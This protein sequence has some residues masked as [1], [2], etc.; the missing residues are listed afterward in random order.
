MTLPVTDAYPIPKDKGKTGPNAK[1][2]WA[3]IKVGESF[4]V[5][6][7]KSAGYLGGSRTCAMKKYGHTYTIRKVE[8]GIRVWRVT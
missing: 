1:Y 3:T 7:K 6:G 4:F 5:A 8:G 2:P